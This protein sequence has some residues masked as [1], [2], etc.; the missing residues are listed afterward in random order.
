MFRTNKVPYTSPGNTDSLKNGAT[1]GWASLEPHRLD[2]EPDSL[3]PVVLGKVES[4][5][6][7]SGKQ[8]LLA[9]FSNCNMGIRTFPM[10]TLPQGWVWGGHPRT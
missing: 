10:Y 3:T 1:G 7:G 5:I 9:A 4:L 8:L 6:L 2:S